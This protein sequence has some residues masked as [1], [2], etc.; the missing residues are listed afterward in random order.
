MQP[1]REGKSV[2]W[3]A[4]TI[5]KPD[6]Q[7]QGLDAEAHSRSRRGKLGAACELLD[8]KKEWRHAAKQWSVLCARSDINRVCLPEVPR[9][10]LD[11]ERLHATR[12]QPTPMGLK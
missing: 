6:R 4:E 3:F 5:C 11:A 9:R 8:G 1:S 2:P 7:Q 10:R 12:A